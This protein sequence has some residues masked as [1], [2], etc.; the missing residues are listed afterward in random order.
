MQIS[1]KTAWMWIICI[2]RFWCLILNLWTCTFV[3]HTI[4]FFLFTNPPGPIRYSILIY[5]QGLWLQSN[6]MF[7]IGEKWQVY[8]PVSHSFCNKLE[9]LKWKKMLN[10]FHEIT[11]IWTAL[12]NH[13]QDH[14][15]FTQNC[16]FI[17]P[18]LNF[19]H[20]IFWDHCVQFS[21][22]QINKHANTYGIRGGSTKKK[23]ISRK[24]H[25]DQIF[26]EPF[27]FF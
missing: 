2:P 20:L 24:L 21:D 14:V 12:I 5:F 22:T 13:S 3:I 19:L 25:R 6:V 8:Q 18:S 17:L 11:R 15:S 7:V 10:M 23:N 1:K 16:L 4:C 26:A 9:A 27:F